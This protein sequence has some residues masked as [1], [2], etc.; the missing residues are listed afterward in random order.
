MVIAG[1]G[2]LDRLIKEPLPRNVDLRNH[3]IGDEEAVDLFSRC[4]L[5]VL[6]YIEASQ[7]A[8]VAAAYFFRKPVVVTSVG[9]LPEYVVDGETGWVIPPN[10][11][12]V[13][14]ET[15][16]AA[17]GDPARLRRMGEAGRQW[18]ERQRRFEE[19]TLHSMYLQV[20]KTGAGW[21]C[22]LMG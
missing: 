3:L 18:Y 10:D 12:Y 19:A 1:P 8:L 22:H 11:P 15:M 4:G 9:A 20:A 17:L 7:S 5:V 13:L 21:R 14:A 6:P 2:R 16:R